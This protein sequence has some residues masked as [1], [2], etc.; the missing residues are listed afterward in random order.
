MTRQIYITIRPTPLTQ[1]YIQ[2]TTSQISN[3]HLTGCLAFSAG[4]KY[5]F[6]YKGFNFQYLVTANKNKK[7]LLLLIILINKKIVINTAKNSPRVY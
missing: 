3:A 4:L 2:R 7:I 5:L 1:H 6:E